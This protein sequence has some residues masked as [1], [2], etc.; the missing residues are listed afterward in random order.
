MVVFGDEIDG[1]KDDE[2]T[3]RKRM[4]WS[5]RNQRKTIKPTKQR[6]FGRCKMSRWGRTTEKK[7]RF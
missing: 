6:N 5:M 4:S 3:E 2:K 1:E 7:K